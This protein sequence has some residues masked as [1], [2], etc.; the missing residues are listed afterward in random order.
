MKK[1]WLF[2]V[3]L[4]IVLLFVGNIGFKQIY[5]LPDGFMA[6]SQEIDEANKS[7]MFGSF[8]NAQMLRDD[9]TVSTDKPSEGVVIFK[10]FGFI[11]IRKVKVVCSGEEEV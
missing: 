5:S 2:G 3:C 4:T 8:V 7:G 10:L 11:P 6:T 9:Q 1:W